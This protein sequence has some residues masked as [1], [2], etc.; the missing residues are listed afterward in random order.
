[1]YFI[2]YQILLHIVICNLYIINYKIDFFVTCSSRNT[3][4][5]IADENLHQ[6][7][8]DG[9]TYSSIRDPREIL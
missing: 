7:V 4:P 1:M 3:L 2:N 6:Y 9:S 8:E 5:S